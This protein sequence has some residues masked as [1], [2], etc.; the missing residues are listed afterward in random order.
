VN[1][2]RGCKD[3][4]FYHLL[5]LAFL[6]EL[7]ARIKHLVLGYLVE[8]L[9]LRKEELVYLTGIQK[10]SYRILSASVHPGHFFSFVKILLSSIP[11]KPSVQEEK[12]WEEGSFWFLGVRVVQNFLSTKEGSWGA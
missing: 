10:T 6:K 11:W 4:Y 7:S 2:G 3:F 1:S 9:S 12:N 5:V 8:G